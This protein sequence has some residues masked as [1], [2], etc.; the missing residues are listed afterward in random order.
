MSK[1]AVHHLDKKE[2]LSIKEKVR[3]LEQLISSQL[4]FSG[5]ANMDDLE[6]AIS[7]CEMIDE[8]DNPVRV[9]DTVL[10]TTELIPRFEDSIN[11]QDKYKIDEFIL[12]LFEDGVYPGQVLQVSTDSLKASFMTPIFLKGKN[13]F[14]YGNGHHNSTN[15]K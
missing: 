2:G 6:E 8:V 3:N 13:S 11:R 12:G 4:E 14:I 1:I 10:D 9:H 15:K 7:S 5:L